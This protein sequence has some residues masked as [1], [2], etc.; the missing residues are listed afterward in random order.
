MAI[1][2]KLEIHMIDVTTYRVRS[3]FLGINCLDAGRK[4]FIKKKTYYLAGF[5]IW[6]V[7]NLSSLSISP[8]PYSILSFQF[9]FFF[10][11]HS[12]VHHT[13]V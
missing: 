12:R 6:I 1:K 10:Q 13:V 3:I 4:M 2:A 8:G 9:K 11:I 5:A 7:N